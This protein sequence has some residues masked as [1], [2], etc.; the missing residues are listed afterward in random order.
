LA[1][2]PTKY[3]KFILFVNELNVILGGLIKP[4]QTLLWSNA[5]GVSWS[6]L[7][8]IAPFGDVPVDGNASRSVCFWRINCSSARWFRPVL[9]GG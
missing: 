6:P 5:E 4:T 7:P 2:P 9:S 1:D 3:K 8:G